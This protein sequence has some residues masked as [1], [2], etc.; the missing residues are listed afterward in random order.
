MDELEQRVAE[1]REQ[2]EL[3][4]IRPALDGR[5]VMELLD[6]APGPPVGDALDFLLEIRLD[7]GPISKEEAS[8]R[9][10]AWARERESR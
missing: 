6:L 10:R 9:L 2:E 8:E 1:L 4:R 3:D 5:E 7:E